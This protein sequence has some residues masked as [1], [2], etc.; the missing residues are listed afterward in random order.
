MKKN[1]T[2]GGILIAALI[3][4]SVSAT[5]H[6]VGPPEIYPLVSGVVNPNVNQQNINQTICVSGW[7]SAV[8][9]PVS[10]TN[11]LKATDLAIYNKKFGTNYGMAD[12]ELDHL[13]SIELGGSPTDPNN[14]YFEPYNTLVGGVVIGAHQKDTVETALKTDV[15]NGQLTL[16]NAQSIIVKDWYAAYLDI[17]G[18]PIPSTT[19]D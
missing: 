17:K 7:T 3:A 8:R 15:C 16:A 11:K 12:G 9:P 18:R 10:Y 5:T 2:I 1:L 6:R 19:D 4:I 14:L 13:I